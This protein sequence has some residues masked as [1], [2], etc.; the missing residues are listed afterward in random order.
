MMD[1]STPTKEKSHHDALVQ[2]KQ[3]HPEET[4]Q[5]LLHENKYLH[6]E[7][8]LQ[9]HLSKSVSSRGMRTLQDQADWCVSP[10]F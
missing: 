10:C 6:R 8:D 7:I 9:D 1:D 5:E 4:I 2:L 3:A